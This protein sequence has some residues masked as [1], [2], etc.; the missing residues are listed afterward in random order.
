MCVVRFTSRDEAR[1]ITN[2][3]AHNGHDGDKSRGQSTE[4]KTR[5]FRGRPRKPLIRFDRRSD[6]GVAKLADARDSKSR[7]VYAPCGFDSLLRHHSTR[8]RFAFGEVQARSW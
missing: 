5:G 4:S 2:R 6:A 1:E 7:G 8:L 3:T